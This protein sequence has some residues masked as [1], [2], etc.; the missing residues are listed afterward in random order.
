MN[1]SII[2]PVFNA[3]QYIAQ[4][5]DSILNQSLDDFKLNVEIILVDDGS[6]DE[7]PLICQ[8]FSAK[9]PNNIKYISCQNSG[10]ANARNMGLDHISQNSDVV[11][12]LDADDHLSKNT[13]EKIKSFFLHH[14]AIQLAVIPLYHFERI[15]TPHRLNY[16]FEQGDR[17]IDITNEYQAI[18]FHIGGCF[19]NAQHFTNKN[20]L[21]FNTDLNFWEDALLINTFLL[22]H[23]KYGVV[24]EARYFY[25]K[26]I[27]EDSLVNNA[28]YQKSRYTEMIKNCYFTVINES[29]NIYGRVIPYVQFLVIYHMRLFLFPKN[30]EIIY[31]VL[32]DQELNEF[33]ALFVKL[34]KEF[35]EEYIQKQQMPFYYKQYL[36]NLRKYG[37]PYYQENSNINKQKVSLT[38]CSLKGLSWYIE[39]H[40]MNKKYMMKSGDRLFI[41]IGNKIHFLS[42]KRLPSKLR[43]IWGTVVRDYEHAGFEA[44]IPFYRSKF[45]FGIKKENG[46][47][48]L[49]NKVNLW[50]TKLRLKMKQNNTRAK[51]GKI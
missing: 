25:R 29:K 7:S 23:R 40:F 48:V 6:T 45:Q 46:E 33:F 41:K 44:S 8:D 10:P 16:R 51:Q 26:R 47:T 39:G 37:W 31:Q 20:K 14:P 3:Q 2:I 38:N 42:K 12:F 43:I 49:L 17:V 9:Y 36:I 4:A 24:S 21:R 22:K 35:D 34:I 50:K 1:F 28:W 19:F 27:E 18:H 11:G 13:L 15:D 30:N 32:T 5:I